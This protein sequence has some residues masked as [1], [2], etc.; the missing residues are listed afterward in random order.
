MGTLPF[1][2]A[3]RGF[4]SSGEAEVGRLRARPGVSA[5]FPEEV[6]GGR[7]GRAINLLHRSSFFLYSTVWASVF[8]L[9][10][11]HPP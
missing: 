2:V 5:R 1:P 3:G 4:L 7:P 10:Y 11:P 6:D 9:S 8:F